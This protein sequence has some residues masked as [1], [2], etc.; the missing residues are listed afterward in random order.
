MCGNLLD[1]ISN[2]Y[3]EKVRKKCIRHEEKLYFEKFP[4][5]YYELKIPCDRTVRR[6]FMPW[7]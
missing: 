2:L 3:D 7:K 6:V 4:P 1:F 5:G